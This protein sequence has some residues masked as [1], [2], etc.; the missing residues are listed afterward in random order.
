M[1]Y[2]QF[3]IWTHQGL[4]WDEMLKMKKLNLFQILKCLYSLKKA[5]EAEFL[6][7]LIDI[8]KPTMGIWN[9]MIETKNQNII[10]LD[11]N[12]FYGY[13]MSRF[14]QTSGFK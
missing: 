5:Q 14:L 13:A 12:N 2:V 7:F 4:S 3:I 1:D 11:M 10:Y 6:I 8:A 9:L